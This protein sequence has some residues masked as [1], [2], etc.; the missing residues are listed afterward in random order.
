MEHKVIE[1]EA[2]YEAALD[3]V[4]TLMDAEPGSQEE[5]ELD[6]VFTLIEQY[7]QEHYPIELS[8]EAD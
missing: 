7:E 2:E 8:K 6:L 1:T 5:E 4:Y 3:Y